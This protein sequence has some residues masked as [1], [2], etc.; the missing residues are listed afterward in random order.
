MSA[1]TL[2][3]VIAARDAARGFST[4]MERLRDGSAR[5]FV[6]LFRN[7]PQAV[8]LHITE[9]ERLLDLAESDE[10]VAA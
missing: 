5:R 3:E 1:F 7:R 9:Y 8:V 6:V 2:N 10:R 4:M